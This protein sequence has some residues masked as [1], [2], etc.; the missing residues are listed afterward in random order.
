M[1]VRVEVS[2]AGI[3]DA[4]QGLSTD[5]YGE[6]GATPPAVGTGLRVPTFRQD[7]T[8]RYLFL[9]ATRTIS[10][11]TKIR[12]IRQYATLGAQITHTSE[13]GTSI[14]TIEFPITT[15]NFYLTDG[16]ISWHLVE[17]PNAHPVTTSQTVRGSQD[18]VCFMQGNSDGP[19]LLYL[20]GAP[21]WSVPQPQFY[22]NN[23]TAYQPPPVW[24]EWQPIAGLGNMHDIRFP[25][26]DSEAWNSLD[27]VMVCAGGGER[28]ISLYASVL[29]TA[30][31]IG[32]VSA[33]SSQGYGPENDFIAAMASL[34]NVSV[35]QF[36][37]VA[38]SIM[39]EDED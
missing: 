1:G 20:A 33:T 21:T 8:T 39:F 38:G 35:V 11:P 13:T 31:A 30:G 14:Q 36:W 19:A 6:P 37:K 9:L 23:M 16:N 29:Q 25:W 4:F 5:P 17:E 18:S 12:G 10:A 24:S 27:G 22:F 32:I 3:D 26:V 28:R 34:S 2:T 15:P 7:D